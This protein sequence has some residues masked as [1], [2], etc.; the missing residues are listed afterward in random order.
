MP[1]EHMGDVRV[2]GCNFLLG[3]RRPIVELSI[4]RLVQAYWLS[5]IDF[6][7]SLAVPWCCFI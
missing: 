2:G 4:D 3:V 7:C 1:S 6:L 5:V